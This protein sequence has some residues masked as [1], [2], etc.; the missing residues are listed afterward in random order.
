[1]KKIRKQNLIP[2]A[3]IES[4]IL[5]IRGQKVMLDADLA[6]LYDVETKALN[7]AVKRNAGRFPSDFMFQLERQELTNLRFQIGTSSLH[8]GGRYLPYVFT[9][10]GIAMLSGVLKSPRAVQVNVAIMRA[11]VRMRGFLLSQQELAERLA[12]LEKKYDSHDD[13]I[14]EIFFAIKKLMSPPKPSRKPKREIGFHT[15]MART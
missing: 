14:Q 3:G 8:G 5:L 4:R 12:T 10:E 7:K 9:Q 11:F 2:V 15:L 6:E 1:M 13:A